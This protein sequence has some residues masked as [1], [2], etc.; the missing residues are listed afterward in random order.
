MKKRTVFVSAIAVILLA[1]SPANAASFQGLGDL[2]GGDFESIASDVSADGSVVVGYGTSAS[3]K[4]AFRWEDD[5][6][7]GLGDLSGGSFESSASS[8]SAD[9]SVVVGRGTPASDGM[10][11]FRWE[12]GIMMGLGNLSNQASGVSA[13]GSVVVGRGSIDL[14]S[15]QPFRWEDGTM[16]ML[17]LG[18]N[19]L[20]RKFEGCAFNVSADG[21]VIVG[22]RFHAMIAGYKEAFRYENDSDTMMCL[23]YP[24]GST[25]SWAFGVSADG[26]TVVGAGM[27]SHTEAFHWADGVMTGLGDLPGGGL[28]SWAIDV[29]ADG[30]VVVGY[31]STDLGTEAFLWDAHNGMQNLK[32]LL[33][34]AY[35]L[36]LTGWTL[37]FASGITPDGLT[38]VGGGINSDG[39]TEAW[40]AEIPEPATLFLLGLGSVFLRRRH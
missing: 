40:I 25:A 11:A 14:F 10:E 36:N 35:G 18:A 1:A 15:I 21:S 7:A 32:D 16:T 33:E 22:E 8:V 20:G 39:N 17:D 4:E 29:S 12:D 23:G 37:S 6:M 30:S 2:S 19:A 34:S 13:D 28:S 27:S 9:G 3:G 31:G 26:S 24:P 5:I 38:I